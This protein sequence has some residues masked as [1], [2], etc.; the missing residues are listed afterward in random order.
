MQAWSNFAEYRWRGV[1][2]QWKV[3]Q[4]RIVPAPSSLAWKVRQERIVPAPSSFGMEFLGSSV[5]SVPGL[6]CLCRYRLV[7]AGGARQRPERPRWSVWVHACSCDAG[8]ERPDRGDDSSGTVRQAE[9]ALPQPVKSRSRSAKLAKLGS[10]G[11]CRSLFFMA[12]TVASH[13]RRS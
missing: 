5:K 6:A 9:L 1:P 4:E 10:A 12:L 3:R 11:N 7:K 13:C 2:R 8:M